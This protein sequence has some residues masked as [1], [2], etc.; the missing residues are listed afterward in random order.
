MDIANYYIFLPS[1]FTEDDDTFCSLHL[2]ND[3]ITVTADGRVTV[4]FIGI[5]NFQ[6]QCKLDSEPFQQCK[7][8][9]HRSLSYT[10]LAGP[11]LTWSQARQLWDPDHLS[12]EHALMCFFCTTG[13]SPVRYFDLGPGQHRLQILPQGCDRENRRKLTRRFTV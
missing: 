11:M 3:G 13:S 7:L 4:E 6:F 12:T 5:G 8:E 10:E 2:I 1:L 9:I